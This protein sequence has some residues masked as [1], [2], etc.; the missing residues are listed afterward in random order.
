M[1]YQAYA[2]VFEAKLA[3]LLPENSLAHQTKLI[4]HSLKQLPLGWCH[5]RYGGRIPAFGDSFG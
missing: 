4:F 2:V 5:W 1:S 3:A